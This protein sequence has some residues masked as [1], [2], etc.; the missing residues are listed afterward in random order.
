MKM[1]T[2]SC[3]T[4]LS[5]KRLHELEASTPS[6]HPRLANHSRALG[7]AH[8]VSTRFI[9]GARVLGIERLDRITTFY[10]DG[11]CR[12]RARCYRKSIVSEWWVGRSNKDVYVV[13]ACASMKVLQ[14]TSIENASD[15]SGRDESRSRSLSRHDLQA[16]S[17]GE[18]YFKSTCQH[19][20]IPDYS[21]RPAET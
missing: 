18:P 11:H 2:K 16:G 19:I 13:C 9:I 5:A 17:F 15:T 14:R 21:S 4:Y 7:Q 12:K 1:T 3:S 20:N 6:P 10:A 8:A